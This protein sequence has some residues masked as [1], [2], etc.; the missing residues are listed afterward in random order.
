MKE[1]VENLFKLFGRW[2]S[3]FTLSFV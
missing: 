3:F 2:I 1:N